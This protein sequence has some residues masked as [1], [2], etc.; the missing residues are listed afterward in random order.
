[1]GTGTI[2]IERSDDRVLTRFC[3]AIVIDWHCSVFAFAQVD[4]RE[5]WHS[6]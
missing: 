2:E 1:M 3:G 4:K 5:V 6:T